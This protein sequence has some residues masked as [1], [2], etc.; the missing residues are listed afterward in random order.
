MKSPSNLRLHLR[1]EPDGEGVLIVNA[2][3]VLRLN[4]TAAELAYHLVQQH[5]RKMM[6]ADKWPL[7][8][9]I[10]PEV[11]LKDYQEFKERLEH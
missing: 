11:A 3:I 1:I 2:S 5:T 7:R 10:Q 6:A 8:Y 4:Q 9:H